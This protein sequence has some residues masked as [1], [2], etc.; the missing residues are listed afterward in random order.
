MTKGDL[1]GDGDQAHESQRPGRLGRA[2]PDL[3]QVFCLVDL[4]RVPGEHAAEI[5]HYDPPEAVRPNSATERPVHGDPGRIHDVRRPVAGR[6]LPRGAVAVRLEP[7]VFG[8]PPQQEVE[9]RQ[10]RQDEDAHRPAGGAP[11]RALDEAPQPGE[12]DDRAHADAGEGEAHRKAPLA[13]EPVWEKERVGGIPKTVAAGA[14]EHTERGIEVPRL[15]HERSQQQ[16]RRHDAHSQLDHDPRPAAIHESADEGAQ[17][18]G[19]Q[20]AEGECAGRQAAL[21]AEFVE[22]RREEEREG[23]ARVDADRHGD[24]GDGHDDPTVEE[25]QARRLDASGDCRGLILATES[26]SPEPRPARSGT[27]PC[28]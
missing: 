24:E 9:R 14:D 15:T 25:G 21:P 23:G 8:P 5:P 17:D 13:H 26:D 6:H 12:Q 28:V 7:K 19:D 20:K 10:Q 1:A 27:I 2:E 11:S 16:P 18:R 22:D 4:H 3:D